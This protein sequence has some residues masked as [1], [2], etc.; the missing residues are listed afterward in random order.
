MPEI[1]KFVAGPFT[2]TQSG[3]TGSEIRDSD[4]NIVAWTHD[5]ATALIISGLLEAYFQQSGN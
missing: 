1:C 2:V 4:G 3:T 5:R